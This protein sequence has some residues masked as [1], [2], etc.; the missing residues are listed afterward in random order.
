MGGKIPVINNHADSIIS[1]N[2]NINY[3]Q[4]DPALEKHYQEH[5]ESLNKNIRLLEDKI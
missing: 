1:N 3:Y 5:I 2:K 4:I